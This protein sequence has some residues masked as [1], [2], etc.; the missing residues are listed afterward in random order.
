MQTK[1]RRR[2][3]ERRR[4]IVEPSTLATKRG[5]SAGIEMERQIVVGL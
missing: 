1:A 2:L 4:R 5:T 3:P